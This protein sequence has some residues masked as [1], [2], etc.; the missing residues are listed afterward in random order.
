MVGAQAMSND[1]LREALTIEPQ[2]C[3]M[4]HAQQWFADQ[5]KPSL[6]INY[7]PLVSLAAEFTKAR[8]EILGAA[9]LAEHREEEIRNAARLEEAELWNAKS[10]YLGRLGL[11]QWQHERLAALKAASGKPDP[12]D[13]TRET[14]SAGERK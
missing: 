6:K 11:E 4:E 7:P 2:S 13:G 5:G 3:D 10:D 12:M 9:P 1:K 14:D 8:S